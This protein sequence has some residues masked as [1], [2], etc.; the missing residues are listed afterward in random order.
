MCSLL[1]PLDLFGRFGHPQQGFNL[2]DAF[3][4]L[5][6]CYIRSQLAFCLH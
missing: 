4:C 5:I 6:I 2:V 1:L 3:C